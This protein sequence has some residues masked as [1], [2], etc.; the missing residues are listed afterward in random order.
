MLEPTAPGRA[1][2]AVGI[3][4]LAMAGLLGAARLHGALRWAAVAGISLVAVVLA[5]LAAGVPDEMLR[6]ANWDALAS[7]IERGISALPGA[8]VPYRGIDK[9]TR[10]VI[11]LGGTMLVVL[12]ALAAFW[13]RRSTTGFPLVALILLV[14]L[15]AVPAVALDLRG[16]VP[17]RR[18]A[19]A[20]RARVPAARAPAPHRGRRGRGARGRDRRRGADRGARAR[21]RRAVV[22]LRDVGAVDAAS[23]STTFSWDHDYGPLDWPRDGREMLRVKAKQAAYWKAESLDI[24]DGERWI[25]SPSGTREA[26][27]NFAARP[28]RRSAAASRSRS[29]STCATCARARSSPPAS[30]STRPR[31]RTAPRSPTA[32]PASGSRAARCAAATPTRR[33]STR[34]SR[35]S[36][37]CAP[38]AASTTATSTTTASSSWPTG[39]A[40]TRARRPG[41]PARSCASSSGTCARPRRRRTGP[42][43]GP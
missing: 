36:A 26:I 30:P 28:T 14:T 11:P 31:C 22:G 3:G 24:F 9:W 40:R 38:P 13:P 2:A 43:S 5:F 4:L 1:W 7:G 34:R 32:R 23:Q 42:A 6:P 25:Q 19:G 35:P 18:A 27:E 33:T 10:I 39:R 21:R 29:R 8:R 41:R 17:A 12:A 16:R 15:Y 20:A 37:S